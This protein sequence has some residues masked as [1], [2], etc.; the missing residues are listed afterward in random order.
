MTLNRALIL[1]VVI[2]Y[3]IVNLTMQ[4]DF[5]AGRDI[6]AKYQLSA[7]PTQAAIVAS[8]AYYAK[9][10]FLLILLALMTCRM[11]FELAFGLSFLTYALTM[12]AF[13]GV[14]RS[15]I[16]Y[17]VASLALLASYFWTRRR[18]AVSIE[19]VA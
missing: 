8:K 2:G 18:A 10:A 9:T 14:G 15:T 13:F 5:F 6:F 16:V 11:R 4:I 1:L 3:V 19:R 12:L 7:T 17:A